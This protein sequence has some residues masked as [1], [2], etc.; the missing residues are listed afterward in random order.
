MA[1]RIRA[2]HKQRRDATYSSRCSL[3]L[4]PLL[5]PEVFGIVE[6]D[7]QCRRLSRIGTWFHVA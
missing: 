2:A 6:V 1:L 4:K 7:E 5:S 3:V